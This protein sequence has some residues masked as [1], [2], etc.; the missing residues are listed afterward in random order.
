MPEPST[1]SYVAELVVRRVLADTEKNTDLAT[2]LEE[3]YPFDQSPAARR[4]WL[5]T[6]LRHEVI[7]DNA[8]RIKASAA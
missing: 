5:E 6:L 4:I 7:A 3:A 1:L 2:A 8:V